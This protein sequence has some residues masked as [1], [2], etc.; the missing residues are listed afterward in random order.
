MYGM[1]VCNCGKIDR[2]QVWVFDRP[3]ANGESVKRGKC[4]NAPLR[5]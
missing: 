4:D 1:T 5:P 2:S 3:G